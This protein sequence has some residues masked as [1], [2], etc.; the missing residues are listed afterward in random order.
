MFGRFFDG[1]LDA[2]PSLQGVYISSLPLEGFT[3]TFLQGE[4]SAS[5]RYIAY[6][7]GAARPW[8]WIEPD[9]GPAGLLGALSGKSRYNLRRQIR[10]LNKHE[11]GLLELIQVDTEGQ[12][13]GFLEQASRVSARTWQHRVLGPRIATDR[14]HVNRFRDLARRG[15]LRA[16]LLKSG[17]EPCAFVVGY[18]FGDVYHYEEIGY[19]PAYEHLSPGT[20]L[21]YL[22]L[23]KLS[24]QDAPSAFNFGI[25][26]AS[27]KRRFAN[28]ESRDAS[29]FLFRRGLGNRLRSDSHRAFLH[30]VGLAKR[31]L[32]RPG[33][34]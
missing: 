19:D 22:I 18:Q 33:V 31:L 3:G 17:P 7:P 8:F 16:F 25:G 2:M 30:G 4:G 14:A 13:D 12:V 21:L 11:G 9:E 6:R 26:D 24:R 29:V 32:R 27:Y 28:R 10:E 20:T 5:K 15:I 23:E 1:L 34:R